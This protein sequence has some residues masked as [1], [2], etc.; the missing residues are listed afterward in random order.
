MSDN[1]WP[2]GERRALSQDEHEAWNAD[3]YPG[4]L[5]IC[6][7]CE[8]PTGRCEEDEIVVDED[9]GPICPECYQSEAQHHD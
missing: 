7:R 5:Q 8:S 1:T 4:T 9:E 2:G 6:A 3:N